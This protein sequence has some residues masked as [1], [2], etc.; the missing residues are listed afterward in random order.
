LVAEDNEV[1][2]LVARAL[3]QSAG[4]EVVIAADG[5]RAVAEA[6][7]S[8]FDIV[9]MDIQMPVM[10][11][12]EA[13]RTLRA[14][15]RF[16]ALPIVA[17]TANAISGER[18]KSLEAGMNEHL[19]KPIDPDI[20]FDTILTILG[21]GG[22]KYLTGGSTA[23]AHASGRRSAKKL[24]AGIDMDSALRRVAGNSRLLRNLILDFTARHQNSAAEIG[25]MLEQGDRDGAQKLAHTLKGVA[26]NLS[27]VLLH[28]AATE[29]D[30]ALKSSQDRN[31]DPLLARLESEMESVAGA[32]AAVAGDSLSEPGKSSVPPSHRPAELRKKLVSLD[33]LLAAN[34]MAAAELLAGLSSMVEAEQGAEEILQRTRRQIREL[35][36]DSARQSVA[37]LAKQ[38]EIEVEDTDDE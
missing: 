27:A 15:K 37:E 36:Y 16:N 2:Q 17:M 18:E 29:L 3:L 19:T 21:T 6:E 5:A 4:M 35:D 34:D 25:R 9:L 13:T 30:S 22:Q 31:F 8:E 33:T 23:T 1:N 12:Y 28:D 26:G 32:A 10:D 38:L 11:G 20:L 14:D 24:T 7:E